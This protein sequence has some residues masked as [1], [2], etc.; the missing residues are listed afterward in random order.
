MKEEKEETHHFVGN[1]SKGV[2][3]NG[4]GIPIKS[5]TNVP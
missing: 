2:N 3:I 5:Q 4:K 1:Y